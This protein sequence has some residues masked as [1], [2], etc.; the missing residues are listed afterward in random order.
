MM[1]CQRPK[2]DRELIFPFTVSVFKQLRD[3]EVAIGGSIRGKI[4]RVSRQ[5]DGLRTR[6]SVIFT[7]REVDLQGEPTTDLMDHVG[8]TT[9]EEIIQLL[10]QVGI[11]PPA[12]GD[13][14]AP[15]PT[16]RK[17]QKGAAKPTAVQQQPPWKADDEDELQGW[18]DDDPS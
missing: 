11:W 2:E 12:G 7:G 6:Y 10:E 13:P 4:L 1:L 8:P 15:K 16:G 18:T 9:R 17:G 3:V 5:G 14:Y